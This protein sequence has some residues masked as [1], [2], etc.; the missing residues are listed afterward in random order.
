V[1]PAANPGASGVGESN[2]RTRARELALYV[3]S[4]PPLDGS[5]ERA[6]ILFH[7]ALALVARDGRGQ[8]ALLVAEE[9]L[10]AVDPQ[11]SGSLSPNHLQQLVTLYSAIAHQF[12]KAGEPDDAVFAA[13]RHWT[14]PDGPAATTS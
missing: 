7:L 11:H 3:I 12:V 8:Q 2:A 6:T 9:M 1:Q 10:A 4:A 14:S 5:E 13:N